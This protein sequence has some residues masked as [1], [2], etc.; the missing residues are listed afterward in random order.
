MVVVPRGWIVCL[1]VVAACQAEDSSFQPPLAAPQAGSD[2]NQPAAST[3][4][5][6]TPPASSTSPGAPLPPPL[7]PPADAAGLAVSVYHL[8]GQSLG[9][10][11]HAALATA[12]AHA[13]ASA[14][15]YRY[16][17]AAADHAPDISFSGLDSEGL[18]TL[19]GAHASGAALTDAAP[20]GTLLLD[21][22]GAAYLPAAGT[23][24]FTISRA[25]GA[26]AVYLD[27][28][29][30][31]GG[32][33]PLL[34][35]AA[36]ALPVSATV[37]ASA[38]TWHT[39]ELVYLHLAQAGVEGAMQLGFQIS[40]PQEVVFRTDVPPAP[41]PTPQPG[42]T[43]S[44]WYRGQASDPDLLAGQM[45]YAAT[46]PPTYVTIDPLM[47]NGAD[48]SVGGGDTTPI[49]AFFG[50]NLTGPAAFDG[51]VLATTLVDFSGQICFPTAGTYTLNI[52]TADDE[53][54]IYLD[55]NGSLGSGTPLIEAAYFYAYPPQTPF[56]VAAPGWRNFEIFWYNRSVGGGGGAGLS[57]QISGP[58]AVLTRSMPALPPPPDIVV[59]ASATLPQVLLGPPQR[60]TPPAFADNTA[61]QA[62]GGGTFAFLPTTSGQS[63]MMFWP[64]DGRIYRSEGPSFTTLASP[65][66]P[67]PVLA[68]SADPNAID[69]S[70]LWL[71]DVVRRPDGSLLGHY[72]G[73]NAV[74]AG[75]GAGGWMSSGV[76]VSSD[77]GV[78]WDK[79]GK[80][81]GTPQPGGA[82]FGGRAL[83]CMMW[84]PAG[85]AWLGIGAGAG[86][87]STDPN[88]AP[89][90]W[91]SW[92]GGAFSQAEP[93]DANAYIPAVLGGL[94]ADIASCKLS[95]NSFTGTYL[96]TW[97]DAAGD[98]IY[99]TTSGNFTTWTPSQ[100]LLTALSGDALASGQ[101]LGAAD[102]VTGR[103]GLLVYSQ[104]P[105]TSSRD[106]DIVWRTYHLGP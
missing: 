3:A 42:L 14:P 12:L 65:D 82:A 75:G 5:G 7:G 28:L 8:S 18:G 39:F 48:I 43:L 98:I 30:A 38:P 29:G 104:T 16:I 61:W 102:G 99:L 10:D 72:R 86:F 80:I 87:R 19:L 15:D 9:V 63:S 60:L 55:G 6:A 94:T 93:D 83:A 13:A 34:Q 106:R 74:F 45:A 33:N 1:G 96:L 92:D 31:A 73:E 32:G 84:D 67:G 47:A 49:N 56:V 68:A 54:G 70:G 4:Q 64:T 91:R 71:T 27:P 62:T 58:S 52:A 66:P 57:L 36:G 2:S 95:Y 88:A 101:L 78:T 40:G 11:A 17:D 76:A 53:V 50:D 69:A 103:D 97:T 77:D 37:T 21:F 20:A 26:A 24:T 100:P 35:A 51:N 89:G 41:T 46:H 22:S 59:A 23:Y 90:T 81:V 79:L 44:M 85:G 25:D 105:P